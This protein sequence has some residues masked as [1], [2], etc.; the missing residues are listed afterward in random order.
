MI[1]A[2]L[3][4][5]AVAIPNGFLL[6]EKAASKKDD[7][8]E[9]SWQVSGKKGA[10]LVVN[11]CDKAELGQAG[12]TSAKTVVY[13]AVPDFSKS[14][15]VILYAAPADA[16]RALREL[17]TA[18]KTCGSSAYRYATSAVTLGD[19]AVRV[20]GQSYQGKKIGIGGERAVVARRANAL[21]L[22]TQAGEWGKPATSDYARQTKDAK[23]MLAK[24]CDIASC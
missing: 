2:I 19:E 14:E 7:N 18:L 11:P 3:L 20:S 4:A 13:T 16:A 15:Q 17:R 23:R 8:P 5:A 21:V 10:K 24:I 12:R 9:T 6:Y 22:Y 1:S